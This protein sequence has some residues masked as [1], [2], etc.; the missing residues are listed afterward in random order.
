[1]ARWA[2][3]EWSARAI[4]TLTVGRDAADMILHRRR[5]QVLE[6][7]EVIGQPVV[8][9][10]RLSYVSRV[11]HAVRPYTATQVPSGTA[12][13]LAPVSAALRATLAPDAA[14]A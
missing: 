7:Y 8:S 5:L 13:G 2:I 6:S 11:E 3:D 9:R 1:M 10:T 4:H 12:T 14:V